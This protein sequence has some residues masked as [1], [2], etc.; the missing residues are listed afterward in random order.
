MSNI[1]RHKGKVPLNK[2][3]VKKLR[4]NTLY[5]NVIWRQKKENTILNIVCRVRNQV[6]KLTRRIQKEFEMKLAT[7]AKTNPKAVCKYMN[8]KTKKREGVSD[9]NTDPKVVKI[10]NLDLQILIGKRQMS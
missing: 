6:H 10:L 2:E 3:S 5:G 4:K 8:S 7:E 1:N 9:L